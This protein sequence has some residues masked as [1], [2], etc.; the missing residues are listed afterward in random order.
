MRK[1]KTTSSLFF[2]SRPSAMLNKP[3]FEDDS[4]YRPLD[5]SKLDDQMSLQG[6]HCIAAPLLARTR[7]DMKPDDFPAWGVDW[8]WGMPI[9]ILTVIFHA[10]VLGLVNRDVTFR[11][12]KSVESRYTF[13][14]VFVIGG[15]ALA[16][17]LLHG[18]EAFGWAIAYRLLGAS[19]TFKS[20][21]LY[22]MS[23]ITSYGHANLYLEPR[24]QLMGTLEALD[25][26]IVFGLTTAF[27]FAVIQRAW[28]RHH[29]PDERS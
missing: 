19:M 3:L 2:K 17:T 22:S 26:W 13:V 9:I 28:L 24:W 10:Y 16:A 23:A 7:S 8:A 21:M 27:L 25:G 12:K 18:F 11:L 15:T 4:L 14:S 20:A 29:L 1:S 5:L 6:H